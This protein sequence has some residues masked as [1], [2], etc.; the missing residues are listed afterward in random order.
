M[1]RHLLLLALLVAGCGA[2]QGPIVQPTGSSARAAFDSW[3]MGD[4]LSGAC[5]RA[6]KKLEIPESVVVAPATEGAWTLMAASDLATALRDLG[7]TVRLLDRDAAA[8][9]SGTVVVVKTT[10][11]AVDAEETRIPLSKW[12]L[13]TDSDVAAGLAAGVAVMSLGTA[14]S[15][16]LG[17]RREGCASVTA[18]VI[19]PRTKQTLSVVTGTEARGGW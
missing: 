15:R 13:L 3:A 12:S 16:D 10:F 2:T 8:T 1:S 14:L 17:Q 19:D 5:R 11:V 9:A 18:Y 4:A 7:K 6:A